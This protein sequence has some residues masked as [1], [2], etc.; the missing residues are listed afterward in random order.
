LPGR[1]FDIW[2]LVFNP[3]LNC[4][5]LGDLP[6][7]LRREPRVLL[8]LGN[9]EEP[10]A[11]MSPASDLDD[12]ASLVK[13][14]VAAISVGLQIAS[15]FIQVQQRICARSGLRELEYDRRRVVDTKHRDQIA[16]TC[17]AG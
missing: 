16:V 15:V 2:R 11:A 10:S 5:Q 13:R 4:I 17:S 9:L 6:Q 1:K 7:G 8:S 3:G 14:A 12:I